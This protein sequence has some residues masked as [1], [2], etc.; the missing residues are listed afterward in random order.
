MRFSERQ[1]DEVYLPQLAVLGNGL[2][3]AI[4]LDRL[5]LIFTMIVVVRIDLRFLVGMSMTFKKMV[6]PVGLGEAEEEQEESRKDNS[7]AARDGRYSS[8]RRFHGCL[9]SIGDPSSDQPERREIESA[10]DGGTRT[11]SREQ[12]REWRQSIRW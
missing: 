11:R 6:H 5:G 9:T 4:C 8:R 7:S 3:C 1:L 10:V 12:R 2:N